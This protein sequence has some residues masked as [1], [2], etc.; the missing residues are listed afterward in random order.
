MEDVEGARDVVTVAERLLRA[1]REPV[2]WGDERFTVGGSVG[3]TLTEAADRRGMDA[4]LR[5]ADLAM[6]VA[7]SGGK[8]R[9]RVFERGMREEV[10][11][12]DELVR[13]LR[14]AVDSGE[15]RV[16]Y[17]PQVDLR[18]G[19]VTGVEALARWQSGSR[20]WVEADGFIPAAEAAG[21][22]DAVDDWVIRQ[23]CTQLR[24]WD[25]AG[26]PRLRMAVNVSPRRLTTGGLAGS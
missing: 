17:Q 25:A 6:Y 8:N 16:L 7:K 13:D 9:V 5:D 22:I 19:A 1:L 4:L 3:V 21:V 12:Q 15:L 26:L 18:T 23:A 24:S 14:S 11:A 10:T 20:G 2:V